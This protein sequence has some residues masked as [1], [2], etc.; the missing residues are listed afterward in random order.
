MSPSGSSL[1]HPPVSHKIQGRAGVMESLANPRLLVG[2]RMMVSQQRAPKLV[3]NVVA[4]HVSFEK[5]K[6]SKQ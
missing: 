2:G 3:V 6:V 5:E 1:P 4:L